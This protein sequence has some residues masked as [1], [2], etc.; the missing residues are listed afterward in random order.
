MATI[1]GAIAQVNLH[2]QELVPESLVDQTLRQSPRKFRRR[3]LPPVVTIHLL[4]LQLLYQVALQG[5]RHLTT[6]PASAS[7]ICQAWIRLPLSVFYQVVEQATAELRRRAQVLGVSAEQGFGGL[8]IVLLDAMSFHTQDTPELARRYRQGG[9]Q[10]KRR[11]GYPVP[12]ILCLLDFASGM[13]TRVIDLPAHRQEHRVLGRMLRVLAAGDLVRADRGLVSFGFLAQLLA[14][15]AQACLRLPLYQLAR[16]TGCRQILRTLGPD[17]HLVQWTKSKD[18]PAS[19]SLTAWKALPDTLIL[20]QIRYHLDQPGFR[21]KI[22][23]VITTLTDPVAYPADQIAAL[24]AKRWQIEVCFR[25]LKRTLGLNL[26]AARTLAGARKELRGYVLVYNLLRLVML[27]AALARQVPWD[28]IGFK[29]A[30]LWLRHAADPQTITRLLVNPRRRRPTEPR[31]RKSGRHRF[32]A[33]KM[34]RQEYKRLLN[35]KEYEGKSNR[36]A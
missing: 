19:F 30:L 7:A 21:T 10:H 1:T 24:Y 27:Q 12:K 3:V 2:L 35:S 11:L 20:R 8:R 34:T 22:I 6:V 13:I 9:N 32:P 5:L 18:R 29:D 28:R 25:S 36:A 14:R 26:R 23:T 17:D 33:L 16:A 15:Q 31:R 4:L